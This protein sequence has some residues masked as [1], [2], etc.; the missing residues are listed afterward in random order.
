MK[1]RWGFICPAEALCESAVT[2]TQTNIKM[3]WSSALR[4][5]FSIL[6]CPRLQWKWLS[7]QW[8]C[9]S[10]GAS[11]HFSWHAQRSSWSLLGFYSCGSLDV[12]EATSTQ[13]KAKAF[14]AFDQSKRTSWFNDLRSIISIR[15]M[16]LYIS[17]PCRKIRKAKDKV[18]GGLTSGP[19]SHLGF[20]ESP[21]RIGLGAEWEQS[22]RQLKYL[23]VTRSNLKQLPC[24][25]HLQEFL[26]VPYHSLLC[27]HICIYIY[28]LYIR[29]YAYCI[30][31]LAKVCTEWS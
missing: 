29:L 16:L 19:G 15:D 1:A 13:L 20:L 26:R 21:I 7:C 8:Y 4:P 30:Q 6:I 18:A 14:K 2:C 9:R 27:M 28:I 11:F 5:F 23:K 12:H 25:A 31:S 17:L 3:H 24:K 10:W 22:R